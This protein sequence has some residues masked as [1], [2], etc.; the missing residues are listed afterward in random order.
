M[1]ARVLELFFMFRCENYY[2]QIKENYFCGLF[3]YAF[4]LMEIMSFKQGN[5]F[6]PNVLISTMLAVEK[7]KVNWAS[8]FS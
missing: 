3:D 4:T 7:E 8:W 6:A 1:I 5:N 2:F